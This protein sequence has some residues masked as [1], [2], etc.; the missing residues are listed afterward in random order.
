VRVEVD[1][2]KC[3]ASGS[4]VLEC[5][6]VFGQDADGIVLLLD[7]QPSEHLHDAV[8]AAADSCPAMCIAIES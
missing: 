2:D 8:Q 7:E 6:E 5:P 3:I 4:C 1:G